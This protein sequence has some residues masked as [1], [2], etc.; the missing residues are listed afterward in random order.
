MVDPGELTGGGGEY[1][2]NNGD[3]RDAPEEDV[4]GDAKKVDP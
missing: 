2:G 1:R 4:T 3:L